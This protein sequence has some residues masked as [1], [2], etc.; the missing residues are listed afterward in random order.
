MQNREEMAEFV[1]SYAIGQFDKNHDLKDED[2]SVLGSSQNVPANIQL[3]KV[4][5]IIC[6]FFLKSCVM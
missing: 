2:A 1:R 3:A 4:Q 6:R 5:E